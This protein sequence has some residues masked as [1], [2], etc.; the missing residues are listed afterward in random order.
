MYTIRITF[1]VGI[2]LYYIITFTDGVYLFF[3]FRHNSNMNE[4]KPVHETNEHFLSSC[5]YKGERNCEKSM[6]INIVDLVQN[7]HQSNAF[8]TN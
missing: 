7:V 8:T 5:I 2:V 4:M 1:Q 3:L 6:N